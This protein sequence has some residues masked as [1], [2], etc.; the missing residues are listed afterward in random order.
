MPVEIR[1]T[2]GGDEK[3]VVRAAHLFSWRLSRDDRTRLDEAQQQLASFDKVDN[4]E[5]LAAR[6]KKAGRRPRA[7][8]VGAR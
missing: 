3:N 8:E 6:A 2:I 5:F 4:K 1:R 7:V